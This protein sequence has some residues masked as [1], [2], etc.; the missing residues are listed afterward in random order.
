MADTKQDKVDA[1]KQA[2]DAR[3]DRV[4]EKN[5]ARANTAA[6]AEASP[7]LDPNDPTYRNRDDETGPKDLPDGRTI[8]ANQAGF[9]ERAAAD[10]A[11]GGRPVSAGDPVRGQQRNPD[12]VNRDIRDPMNGEPS[13]D[14]DPSRVEPEP[15]DNNDA[16]RVKQL[17]SDQKA[18]SSKLVDAAAVRQKAEQEEAVLK[19][20]AQLKAAELLRLVGTPQRRPTTIVEYAAQRKRLGEKTVNAFVPKAFQ[21]RLDD[22]TMLD[23]LPGIRQIPASLASHWWLAAN[24]VTVQE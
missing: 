20:E 12:T 15:M 5:L 8:P 1:A 19:N 18:L 4:D 7:N 14:Y 21:L 16:N 2:A 3:Q 23:M 11:L 6:L 10:L 9:A 17:R 22:H 24:N 13:R